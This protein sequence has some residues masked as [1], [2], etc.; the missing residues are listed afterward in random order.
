M[1]DMISIE[2]AKEIEKCPNP[3]RPK[4]CRPQPR[5]SSLSQKQHIEYLNHREKIRNTAVLNATAW[6]Q[7]ISVI[8][9]KV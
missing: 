5:F 3:Q 7:K 8:G 9:I 6:E 1:M 2:N 4:D